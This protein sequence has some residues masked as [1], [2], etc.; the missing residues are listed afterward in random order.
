MKKVLLGIA[1]PLL[2]V[3]TKASAQI[4]ADAVISSGPCQSVSP[5][6]PNGVIN[7][8]NA[9]DQDNSNYSVIRTDLGIANVSQVT[10]GFTQHGLP[11]MDA[12]IIIEADGGLISAD[13]LEALSVSLYSSSNNL[14]GKRQGFVLADLEL[15][16]NS[17]T[18]YRLHVNTLDN[19]TDIASI[20]IELHGLATASS[21]IRLY[22]AYLISFCPD[23]YGDILHGSLNAQNP[24]NVIS[25]ATNDYALLMPPLL[26][27]TAY[28]DVAFSTPGQPGKMVNFVLGE[29]NT[30]LSASLLKNLTITV[31]NTQGNVVASASNFS[32]LT[33]EIFS[34]GRFRIRVKTPKGDYQIGRARITLNGLINVLTTLKVYRS[35]IQTNDR[36]K[37]P[38]I[39]ANGPTEICNGSL[40][41]LT[42]KPKD[43]TLAYQWYNN[44]QTIQGANGV[45]YSASQTGYYFV[46]VTNQK[47]C[48][49][50]SLQVPVT[51]INCIAKTTVEDK[52]ATKISP[53]PFSVSATLEIKNTFNGNANV[54]ITN[55]AGNVVEQRV[56]T[57]TGSIRIL[58]KAPQ[59]VYFVRIT[60]GA[61]TE[62]K[63]VIKL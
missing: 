44:S 57:G 35:T 42:A 17:S 49:N 9:V 6:C 25:A 53:N 36:P 30:L 51:V 54:V 52:M 46:A 8:E 19:I 62:T 11:G 38:I 20:K 16:T 50:V 24:E 34:D 37:Q 10:L 32:L 31:Y 60:S 1:M 3:T 23:N 41:K 58:E 13:V 21:K 39:T 61:T 63:T 43:A 40:V 2:L 5:G 56:I 18:R 55:K 28:I 33:T 45:N 12:V 29:G 22:V 47:G 14:V 48:S 59:G 7:P 27:G 15:L 26:L 4:F